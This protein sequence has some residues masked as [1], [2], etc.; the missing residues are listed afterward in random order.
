MFQNHL[1]SVF[2]NTRL[3][4]FDEKVYDKILAIN[5][6]EGER[7]ELDEPVNAQVR[8]AEAQTHTLAMNLRPS[9][10]HHIPF[11]I[12]CHISHSLAQLIFQF[13]NTGNL[14][15]LCGKSNCAYSFDDSVVAVCL[16]AFFFPFFP[17]RLIANKMISHKTTNR[18]VQSL[19]LTIFGSQRLFLLPCEYIPVYLCLVSCDY[20]VGTTSCD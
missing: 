4:T 14:P 3:V 8:K 1:L 13:S 16:W 2:D 11:V 10:H 17:P 18:L 15:I 19:D 7:V 9:P 6:Q 12:F 5:S 20:I